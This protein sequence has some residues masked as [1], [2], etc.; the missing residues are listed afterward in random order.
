MTRSAHKIGFV[1]EKG[2]A[3]SRDGAGKLVA[4]C[5][6][7]KRVFYLVLFVGEGCAGV[8]SGMVSTYL[9]RNRYTAL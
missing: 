5:C 4:P 6:L 7:H 8:S 2:K 9:C 3:V 1:R